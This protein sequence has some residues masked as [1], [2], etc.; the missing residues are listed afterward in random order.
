MTISGISSLLDRIKSELADAEGDF[1]HARVKAAQ[2][3]RG[4]GESEQLTQNHREAIRNI[5]MNIGLQPSANDFDMEADLE[6]RLSPRYQA[7]TDYPD[8]IKT[9]WDLKL[10]RQRLFNIQRRK[11]TL[12]PHA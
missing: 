7:V 12:L 3:A 5:E 2:L 6:R 1:A 9:L 10:A 4:I 8:A 11:T